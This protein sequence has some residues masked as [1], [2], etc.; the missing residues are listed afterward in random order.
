MPHRQQR[1]WRGLI[2]SARACETT[3]PDEPMRDSMAY[4]EI[5]TQP[6]GDGTGEPREIFQG[7]MYASSPGLN[8]MEH[9]L[10]DAWVIA[11][12][13]EAPSAA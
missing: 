4:L 12:Q 10:Y 13:A 2:F 9:P 3:A 6:R 5:F 1:R 8:P 11:C 7:W